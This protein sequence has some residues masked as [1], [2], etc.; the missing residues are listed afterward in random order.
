MTYLEPGDE[1]PTP[2]REMI[3]IAVCVVAWVACACLALYTAEGDGWPIFFAAGVLAPMWFRLN[4]FLIAD[5]NRIKA[6]R[7][8]LEKEIRRL[9]SEWWRR[10]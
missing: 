5:I 4:S 10:D 7:K 1:N 8:R 9:E 3:E 6:R 2:L